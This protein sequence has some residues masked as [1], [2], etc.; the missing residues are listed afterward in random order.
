VEALAV[1]AGR[2]VK[3]FLKDAAQ[4]NAGAKPALLGN[5]L[6]GSR[7]CSSSWRAAAR[8]ASVT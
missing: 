5:A 2:E 6:K 4:V 8:R 3:L 1:L 7:V